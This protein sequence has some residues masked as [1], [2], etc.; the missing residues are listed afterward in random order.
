MLGSGDESPRED[1]A[2]EHARL[3]F[4]QEDAELREEMRKRGVF[5]TRQHVFESEM[6]L[7]TQLGLLHESNRADYEHDRVFDANDPH[8]LL[9]TA[10]LEHTAPLRLSEQTKTEA[11]YTHSL[12]SVR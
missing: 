9:N 10:L 6:V 11:H 1:L 3:S 2:E 4:R 12:F 8:S 7:D 5:D